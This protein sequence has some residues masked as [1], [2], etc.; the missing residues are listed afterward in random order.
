MH[1]VLFLKASHKNHKKL[2]NI[3][4]IDFLKNNQNIFFGQ[5]SDKG[6]SSGQYQR[7]QLYM[8][9]SLNPKILILDE[10]LN[11]IELELEHHII[12]NIKKYFEDLTLLQITHRPYQKEFYNKIIN[13]SDVNSDILVEA[14]KRLSRDY[15]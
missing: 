14:Q 9:L 15:R 5:L 11:A 12:R 4:G 13:L 6:L 7:I 3:C 1:L 2:M 10:A 8:A